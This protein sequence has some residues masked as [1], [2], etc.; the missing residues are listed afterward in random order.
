MLRSGEQVWG[1]GSRATSSET[2]NSLEGPGPLSEGKLARGGVKPSSEAETHLRG[3]QAL[4][5]G[6]GFV[7]RCLALE[8][9]RV[10]PEGSRG[11]APCWAA[12]AF[13]AVGPSCPG[14]PPR[15]V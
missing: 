1:R 15:R 8:R 7:E 10:S 12:E 5:R 2:E 14:S 13:W 3:H 9:G 11:S 6:G 4:E